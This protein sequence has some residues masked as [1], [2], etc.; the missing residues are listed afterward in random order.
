MGWADGNRKKGS[1]DVTPSTRTVPM[2]T[3]G[4]T[5]VGVSMPQSSCPE[6]KLGAACE[7]LR[8]GAWTISTEAACL[9]SSSARCGGEPTP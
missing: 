2:S 6:A 7:K 8:Y 1:A 4:C 5:F 9:I 3:R